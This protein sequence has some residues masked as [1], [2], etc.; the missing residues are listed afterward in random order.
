MHVST[1]SGKLKDIPAVNCNTL[2]NSYCGKMRKSG[3]DKKIYLD[4]AVLVTDNFHQP[5][6][7]MVFSENAGFLQQYRSS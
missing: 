6:L 5:L 4:G 3:T 2:S 1:M 7:S